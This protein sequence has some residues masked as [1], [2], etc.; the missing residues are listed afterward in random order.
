M[1]RRAPLFH[2]PVWR[3]ALPHCWQVKKPW[4]NRGARRANIG[5]NQRTERPT[6][7]VKVELNWIELN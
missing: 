2:S 6:A 1:D 3:A 4:A 5:G 7:P